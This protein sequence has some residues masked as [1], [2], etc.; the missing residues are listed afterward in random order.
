MH[1]MHGRALHNTTLTGQELTAREDGC[2]SMRT[3]VGMDG[4]P[5]A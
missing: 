3:A 2:M 5:S 1:S 4:V